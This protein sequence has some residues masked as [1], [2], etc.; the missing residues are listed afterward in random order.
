MVIHYYNPAR[1]FT[2]HYSFFPQRIYSNYLSVEQGAKPRSQRWSNAIQFGFHVTSMVNRINFA[3]SVCV[4]MLTLSRQGGTVKL[5]V[6]LGAL[7]VVYNWKPSNFLSTQDDVSNT[8]CVFSAKLDQTAAKRHTHNISP[9]SSSTLP[10]P[11]SL[12]APSPITSI[13]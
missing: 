4:C 12:L 11:S 7:L 9:S 6:C 2:W 5:V 1:Q 10:L 3:C 13:Y 8:S